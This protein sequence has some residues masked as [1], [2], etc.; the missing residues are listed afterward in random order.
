MHTQTHT[1]MHTDPFTHTVLF[2]NVFAFLELNI[3]RSS[4]GMH[5]C[6]CESARLITLSQERLANELFSQI[7]C[8]R[9]WK[10]TVS[11]GVGG[12]KTEWLLAQSI[13]GW[14]SGAQNR[15]HLA[16]FSIRQQLNSLA[17]QQRHPSG[18]DETCAE[19]RMRKSAGR[20]QNRIG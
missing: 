8:I 9:T 3:I 6:V 16:S 17:C 13:R 18:Q 2:R 12:C 15:K 5:I 7:R 10:N 20:G 19:F 4:A 1:C 14:L 11:M